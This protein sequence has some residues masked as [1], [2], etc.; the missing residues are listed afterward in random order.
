MSWEG[1]CPLRLDGRQ[2]GGY[3]AATNPIVITMA[4]ILST[5]ERMPRFKVLKGVAHNI[6]HSFTSLM[7]YSGD[8]YSMGHIL[9]LARETGNNT[10]TIDLLT[11]Q[12]S[13]ASLLRE[14]IS[15]LPD[16][17]SKMFSNMVHSS[18][19]DRE[20]LR[21]ATLTLIY[22]LQQNRPSPTG[23]SS[24]SPYTC[25]VSIIDVRG[26]EYAAWFAGWWQVERERKLPR[27]LCV[28]PAR[29]WWN[30]FSWF[31]SR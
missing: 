4:A 1:R 30:P 16:W 18:G 8:D 10:L 6:G 2:F 15:G 24:Q 20:L 27:M 25:E 9:R 31:R 7:N 21:S 5:E 13:P 3:A 19:S 29:R 26:K 17:Y 12:G 22:N 11:G 28:S 14:P 23:N